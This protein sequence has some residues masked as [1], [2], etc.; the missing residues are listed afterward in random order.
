MKT[1]NYNSIKNTRVRVKDVKAGVTIYVAH[2]VYGIE[3][4]VIASRPYI[5]KNT[6]SLFAKFRSRLSHHSSRTFSLADAGITEGDS[7]NGRRAF[8]KRKHAV[9][10]MEKW[11][12]D[13]GFIAQHKRHEELCSEFPSFDW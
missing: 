8:F 1:I 13:K 7:Y 12:K 6:G 10:W 9:A 5:N 11:G 2:P 3:K 4:H